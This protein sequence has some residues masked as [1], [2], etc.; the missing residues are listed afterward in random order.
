MIFLTT[1]LDEE[2]T[3]TNNSVEHY[4]DHGCK[5]VSRLVRAT[6]MLMLISRSQRLLAFYNDQCPVFNST[7]LLWVQHTPGSVR[8]ILASLARSDT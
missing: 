5:P 8:N 1:V 7:G 3:N 2:E 4:N 6:C